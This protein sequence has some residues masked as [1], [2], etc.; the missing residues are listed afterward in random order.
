[1]SSEPLAIETTTRKVISRWSLLR[2]LPWLP[3]LIIAT[4]VFVGVFAPL[5]TSHSPYDPSLPNRL[6]PPSWSGGHLLGTDTMG[7]DMLTRMFFGARVTLI[8]A[9]L[10]ILVGGGVGLAMGITAGYVGGRVGSIIMRTVDATMSF[11]TILI[12]LLL[13]VTMGPGLKT[14]V[15]A[16][17]LIIWAR[18]A[19]L[20]R[21]EVL[22]LREKD[23]IDHAK[24][25][26]CSDLRIMAFHIVPNVLN[27][28]MV[29][30]SLEVGYVIVVE[31]TLSFLGAGIP[32]PT[33]SWGQMVSEGRQ[34]ISS[35]WW[36]SLVPGAAITLVVLS[37][38]LFGD[39][40]RDYLD[41]KLRHL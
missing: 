35:A 3:L 39:W 27:T 5:L 26:G 17:S 32:P 11:P 21:G 31:A 37:L 2:R 28:F 22:A 4:V 12:A 14:V 36:I 23:F 6:R 41:P 10:T 19:R 16:V 30:V 29:L 15:I 33:P 18:F 34:Y 9:A 8:V 38:N 40:L 25:I 7:R 13:A 20:V 1:M 24:V